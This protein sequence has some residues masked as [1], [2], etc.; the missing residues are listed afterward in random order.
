MIKLFQ[1]D[2]F[3]DQI[4]RGNPAAVCILIEEKE[5]IWMQKLAAEM[6]LSETAFL[7][8]NGNEFNLRW[9]TP[10]TEVKLCG[11]AT[12]ASA[13]VLFTEDMVP[14][15]EVINFHT[16]SGVLQA[17]WV[18]NTVMLNFPAFREAEEINN[19]AVLFALG[20]AEGKIWQIGPHYVVEVE[21]ADMVRNLRPDFNKMKEINLGE[22]AVTSVSDDP[23]Y[24]FLSRFFAPGCGIDEDPVTGS[25]HCSLAPFWS[26][27]LG[28]NP[29]RA[30]Q[31]S[32]RGGSLLVEIENERVNLFG[33]AV[34][35]FRAE[36]NS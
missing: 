19:E 27:K 18:D 17:R 36:L 28:K 9:F 32:S 22:V 14:I 24:D 23:A 3:T 26:E 35:V 4:F 15:D 11:H 33:K 16:L 20:I 13:W 12:L 34:T 21:N 31:A 5:K 25:A 1:V 7:R 8:R 29:V 10:T 2:A 6:N 30:Y